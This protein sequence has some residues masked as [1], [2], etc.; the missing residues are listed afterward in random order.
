MGPGGARAARHGGLGGVFIKRGKGS[1][2]A[3]VENGMSHIASQ[4]RVEL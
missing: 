2:V 4:S 3:H 1:C